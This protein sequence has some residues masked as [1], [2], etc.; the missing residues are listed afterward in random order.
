MSHFPDLVRLYCRTPEERF[1]ARLSATGVFDFNL[2]NPMSKTYKCSQRTPLRMS[3]VI[4][5]DDLAFSATAAATLARVGLREDVNVEWNSAVWPVNA[6]NEPELGTKALMHALN[7]HLVLLPASCAQ[8]LPK[9]VFNWLN[10]WA[11]HRSIPDAALGIL[12]HGPA[13]EPGTLAPLL[14]FGRRHGLDVI[15]DNQQY[16]RGEAGEFLSTL[17]EGSR[18]SVG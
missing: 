1:H 16:S 4:I 6:L 3:A 9:W 14:D 10:D 17:P 7:A 5:C 18:P 13:A 2:K 11:L 12:A 8:S 15:V